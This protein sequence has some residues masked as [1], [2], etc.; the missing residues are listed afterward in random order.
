MQ[1]ISQDLRER[2]V[3]AYEA[4][5]GSYRVLAERFAGS[6]NEMHGPLQI[7][8]GHGSLAMDNALRHHGIF[9]LPLW[10]V[11]RVHSPFLPHILDV[12]QPPVSLG[13]YDQWSRSVHYFAASLQI[14]S[15][16]G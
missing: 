3:A 15:F 5:E 1:W 11:I 6:V 12:L 9:L 8:A 13:Q 16:V 10:T 2:I 7:V 4:G 14:Q